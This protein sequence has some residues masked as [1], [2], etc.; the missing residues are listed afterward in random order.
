ME[1]TKNKFSHIHVSI[2]ND[3]KKESLL[4][5]VY[6]DLKQQILHKDK[7]YHAL[8]LHSDSLENNYNV[9]IDELSKLKVENEKLSRKAR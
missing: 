4:D 6:E 9:N 7:Q 8:K 2:G 5:S 1:Q 3:L